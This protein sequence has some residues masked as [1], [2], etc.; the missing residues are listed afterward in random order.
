MAQ[1]TDYSLVYDI[2]GSY[3]GGAVALATAG[4]I[5]YPAVNASGA[6]QIDVEQPIPE[7]V[8]P[9]QQTSFSSKGQDVTPY[10]MLPDGIQQ[11]RLQAP[12]GSALQAY[13]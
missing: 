10:F 3:K 2:I 6:W 4:G 11:I 7:T 12:A 8:S 1:V 13:L 9:V 5:H